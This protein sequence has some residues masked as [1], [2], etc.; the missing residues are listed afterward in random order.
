MMS[1]QHGSYVKRKTAD[2]GND[3]LPLCSAMRIVQ[4]FMLAF[5]I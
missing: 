2:A 1:F 3:P 4:I 5:Y